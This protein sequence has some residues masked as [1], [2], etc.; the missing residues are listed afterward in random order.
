M[1]TLYGPQHRDLKL[2]QTG[3]HSFREKVQE[4]NFS[5]TLENKVRKITEMEQ[6]QKREYPLEFE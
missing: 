2:S 5:F 6:L 4:Q 1:M 3:K